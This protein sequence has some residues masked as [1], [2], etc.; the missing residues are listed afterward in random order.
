MYRSLLNNYITLPENRF[1]PVIKRQ[2]NLALQDN[3]KI[4]TLGPMDNVQFVLAKV[5]HRKKMTESAS[6]TS[7][8]G[9]GDILSIV[10][11]EWFIDIC[12]KASSS[13]DIGHARIA[14]FGWLS[15]DRA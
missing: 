7:F 13:V 12:R 14:A 6:C 10:V 3:P 9:K 1:H 5:F 11:D 8:V 4:D 15:C 2:L